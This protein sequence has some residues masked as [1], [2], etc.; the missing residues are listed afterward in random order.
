[1][2]VRRQQHRDPDLADRPKASSMS[3][4]QPRQRHDDRTCGVETLARRVDGDLQ[5]EDAV[6]QQLERLACKAQTDSPEL[7]REDT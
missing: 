7:G 5:S 1:M 3:S 4:D 6:V 2:S